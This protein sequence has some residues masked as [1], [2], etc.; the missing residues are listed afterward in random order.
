MRSLVM[1]Y[2]LTILA[3]AAGQCDADGYAKC[4]SVYSSLTCQ[5]GGFKDEALCACHAHHG[6]CAKTHNCIENCTETM[7]ANNCG[8]A[9]CDVVNVTSPIRL[10]AVYR[11]TK[12]VTGIQVEDMLW[13]LSPLLDTMQ[14]HGHVTD[15]ST[16]KPTPTAPKG[17]TQT[18][19]NNG[20]PTIL[21]K[22]DCESDE[23]L[24][25]CSWTGSTCTTTGKAPPATGEQVPGPDDDVRPGVCARAELAGKCHDMTEY[26]A[27]TN[28]TCMP[29]PNSVVVTTADL[30][31]S[32]LDVLSCENTVIGFC[33]W[34]GGKCTVKQVQSTS[35]TAALLSTGPW[36]VEVDV[37]IQ[38]RSRQDV[39]INTGF[40][41]ALQLQLDQ[42]PAMT[43][44]TAYG[45]ALHKASITE[46]ASV[47]GT[48]L[49][50]E[51]DDDNDDSMSAT[52]SISIAVAAAALVAGLGFLLVKR[53]KQPKANMN[54]PSLNGEYVDMQKI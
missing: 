4:L 13:A 46:K 23:T 36:E 10:T 28:N 44:W 15:V 24:G 34:S 12:A 35:R 42:L 48:S 9:W 33:S 27:E 51:K 7:A 31:P 47:G 25:F 29:D 3:T 6:V 50:P 26:C 30:C 37:E 21:Y 43:D 20:C 40:T 53:T 11:F 16:P 49:N 2:L 39:Y 32:M 18:D 1:T 45:A 14:M 17:I 54:S 41:S 19:I 8:A 5:Q 52:A 22:S 38:K